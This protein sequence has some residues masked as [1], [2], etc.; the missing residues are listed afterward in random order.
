ME[1]NRSHIEAKVEYLETE[2]RNLR[3]Y[4]FVPET[5]QYLLEQLDIY[6][7]ILKELEIKEHFAAID[8]EQ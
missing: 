6:R 5:Y 8:S 7:R 4:H 1:T 2:L 3:E